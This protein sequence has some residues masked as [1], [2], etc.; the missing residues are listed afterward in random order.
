MND[1]K[2]HQAA[3][4]RMKPWAGFVSKGY[5]V[6][7]VG[8]ITDAR[9]R[10]NFEAPDPTAVG[11]KFEQTA[12]PQIGAGSNAENWFELVNW[13]EAAQDARSRYVMITLGANFG[14]QATGAYRVLQL[15]TR[16]RANWARSIPCLRTSAG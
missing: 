11:G 8:V 14:Y 3:I 10:I 15:R 12:F 1:L 6:D 9:F 4:D 13:I 7:C 5:L 2:G 16:C